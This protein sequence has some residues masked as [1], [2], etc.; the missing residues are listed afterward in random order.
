MN[1]KPAALPPKIAVLP[2]D[3]AR[4]IP[5]PWFVHRPED[6]RAS[7]PVDFRIAD[8]N[9]RA[10]AFK[11]NL[12][13]VCGGS[14]GSGRAAALIGGM[15]LITC[16]SAEPLSHYECALWSVTT[17]CPFLTRPAMKRSPRD[18]PEE[19][20]SAGD[21]IKRNP[22]VICLGLTRSKLRPFATGPHPA[23]FLFRL[24]ATWER[25]DFYREGRPA[26]IAEV[27]ESVRTGLPLLIEPA[28]KE[29]LDAMMELERA[30]ARARLA[31]ADSFG[32]DVATLEQL[33]HPP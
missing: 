16:T 27:M 12:C 25:L 6:W 19:A 30:L 14:L 5:I 15:C 33:A 22:G 2:I 24:P 31:I 18:M 32:V 20:R 7:D 26:T 21:A 11:R 8:S 9:K 17:G 10:R 1:E 3:A 4:Q 29:G 13:W 28:E 23:D